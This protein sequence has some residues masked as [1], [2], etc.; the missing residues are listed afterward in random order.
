[1]E[2]PRTYLVHLHQISITAE[3][4]IGIFPLSVNKCVF[5]DKLSP[6]GAAEVS[7]ESAQPTKWSFQ[8]TWYRLESYAKIDFNLFKT[9]HTPHKLRS[10]DNAVPNKNIIANIYMYIGI[11]SS[12]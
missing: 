7:F 5:T 11:W 1:M 4:R 8:R 3:F 12:F 6:H 10:A 9:G 2:I